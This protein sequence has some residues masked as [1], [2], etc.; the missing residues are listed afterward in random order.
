MFLLACLIGIYSY[1]LFFLGLFHLLHRPL[2][3]IFTLLYF[4]GIIFWKRE[5][6]YRVLKNVF[7]F[8]RSLK[9]RDVLFAIKKHRLF[10]LLVLLFSLQIVVNFI[11]VLGPE[12]AFDALWYHLTLPKLYLL[13]HGVYHIP[14]NLLYYSDMPKLAEMLYTGAL[15]FGTETFVKSIQW[16]FGLLTCLSIYIFARK[17]FS[18]LIAFIAVVIFYANLVVAWESITAYIDLVRAFFEILALWVFMNWWEG[19]KQKWLLLSAVMIGLAITTKLL[20]IGS[21]VIFVLLIFWKGIT[22]KKRNI[23]LVIKNI[24][25]YCV[26]AFAIPAPWMVFA[27]V[28]TGNPVYPFFSDLYYVAPLAPDPLLFVQDIVILLTHASD[29]INLIYII[30]LPFIIFYFRKLPKG[31]KIIVWYSLLALCIWYF[32]PRTGG[33]RFILPYLPAMS[34]VVAGLIDYTRKQKKVLNKL[35]VYAVILLAAFCVVYRAGANAKY[36]PVI[37]GFQAKEAF[38]SKYLT[39]SFGDFYDIDGY[40]K[41]TITS[42]DRVLLLG[43]HN[44]YYVDFPFVDATWLSDKD[45]FNYI[46]IQKALLPEEYKTWKLVYFNPL[47][48]VEL[49]KR[50]NK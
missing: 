40:F 45:T 24:M 44:L 5:I 1:S 36:L 14:G 20:A 22:G 27:F 43:F 50:P 30:S 16:I 9:G 47:T 37:F 10:T 15:S 33:G 26:V 48:M 31:I 7:H 17:W 39:F 46:A 2:V 23:R 19:T 13:N 28:H 21:L 12:F 8:V 49:Y 42:N 34:I 38:L 35:L 18:P 3:I 41:N 6:L 4:S 25:L 29:P 11:G 32:T